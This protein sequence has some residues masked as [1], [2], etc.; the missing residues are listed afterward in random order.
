MTEAAA[1]EAAPDG[2]PTG[3]APAPEAVPEPT[4]EDKYESKLASLTGQRN[5]LQ[6]ET[7]KYQAHAKIAEAARHEA[8]QALEEL[9]GRL[10]TDTMGVLKDHGRDYGTLT[11]E[12]LKSP[13]DLTPEQRDIR[14]LRERLDATDKRDT[15]AREQADTAAG[16][17]EVNQVLS[18]IKTSLAERGD[19]PFC[20]VLGGER[21]IS[22]LYNDFASENQ[23]DPDAATQVEIALKHESDVREQTHSHLKSLIEADKS[24]DFLGF[25]K[26]LVQS[27][28]S[29]SDRE[30]KESRRAPGN[31]SRARTLTSRASAQPGERKPPAERRTSAERMERAS[32]RLE[33]LGYR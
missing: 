26:E 13:D 24:G 7:L 21:E 33:E 30:A 27:Q 12:L 14:D 2:A 6:K 1:V 29:D 28:E 3:D 9:Q 4:P 16:E 23:Y 17:R 18:A 19:T 11:A 10:K 25:L 32:Q 20:A 15:E 8:V 22:K 31:G 5:G